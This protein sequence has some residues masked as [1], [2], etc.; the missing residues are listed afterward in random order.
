MEYRIDNEI[1]L[2]P[3]GEDHLLFAPRLGCLMRTNRDG[4]DLVARIQEGRATAADL[5]TRQFQAMLETGLVNG[6]VPPPLPSPEGSPYAPTAVT[7]FLTNRCNLRC[8]YCYA[9]GQHPVL[10]LDRRIAEAAIDR[11]IAN[12]NA[13]GVKRV[14]VAFHGGGEPTAAWPELVAAV[15]YAT[16]TTA[17]AGLGLQ[18][19]ITTNGCWTVKQARWLA[20]HFPCVSISCDG[21]PD[22]QNANRPMAGGR[23]SSEVLWRNVKILEEANCTYFFQATITR[24]M[25]PRMPEIV[26][27]FCETGKPLGIKLEPVSVT[28]RFSG[29]DADVPDFTE[30]AEWFD[31]AYDVARAHGVKLDFPSFRLSGPP[32]NTFCG[33]CQAPFF[34][35]PDGLVSACYETCWAGAA[36]ADRLLIGRYDAATHDFIIDHP[37]LERLRQ[38]NLHNLAHCRDCF[39]KYAC[40]GDC[41]ARNW[42][43]L[44]NAQIL[45][46]GARCE[47]IRTTGKRYLRRLLDG[48]ALDVHPADHPASHVCEPPVA[49][50]P[51]YA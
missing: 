8:S 45:D 24:E 13:A 37:R 1:F 26:R 33:T 20:A 27:Y 7:L 41:P 6:E 19:G 21:P 10:V 14:T 31:Q 11:V 47:L 16:R 35:T 49:K 22:I 25:A 42:R 43:A 36:H 23:G 4:V 32:Q 2:V 44:E 28:G 40:A 39:C 29:H 5:A 18:L 15:E 48:T 17:A 12:A 38:R 3:D 30:F 46:T 50:E 34:V 51:S 9:A